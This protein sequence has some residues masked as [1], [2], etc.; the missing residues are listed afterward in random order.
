MFDEVQTSKRWLLPLDH[1]RHQTVSTT[2]WWSQLTRLVWRGHDMR[3]LG[4]CGHCAAVQQ[5]EPPYNR[6]QSH[7]CNCVIIIIINTNHLITNAIKYNY[8]EINRKWCRSSW[9][10]TTCLG[11]NIYMCYDY[12][13]LD[14][15]SDISAYTVLTHTLHTQCTCI[16]VATA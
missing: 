16:C 4:G 9:T 13:H 11:A 2:V 15:L 6:Y 12:V 1:I 8:N 5:S 3:V 10:H 14:N 7:Q